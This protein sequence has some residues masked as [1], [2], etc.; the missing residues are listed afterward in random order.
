MSSVAI[1]KR[2][3]SNYSEQDC[4]E[5]HSP[6]ENVVVAGKN[7]SPQVILHGFLLVTMRVLNSYNTDYIK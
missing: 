7:P 5:L 6:Y 1:D 3:Q 4:A 2:I